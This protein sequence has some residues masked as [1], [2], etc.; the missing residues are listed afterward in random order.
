MN[1]LASLTNPTQLLEG[2]SLD[3]PEAP[4]TSAPLTA[5]LAALN[6]TDTSQPSIVE[7]L[8]SLTEEYTGLIES[9][10]ELEVR[11]KAASQE[12]Q[13]NVEAL[14]NVYNEA[15]KAN[16]SQPVLDSIVGAAQNLI[17]QDIALTE[18]YALEKRAIQSVQDMAS[19][20]PVQAELLF[21]NLYYGGPDDIVRDINTKYMIVDR[22]IRRA[23]IDVD[24]QPWFNDVTNFL[25]SW[26]PLNYS[27]SRADLVDMDKA[28]KNWYDGILPGE[29]LER[30]S[31][32]MFDVPLE[33][34]TG[35]V[36]DE[37]IPRV[38][39][40]STLFGYFDQ[41]E[42]LNLMSEV[43]RV[44]NANMTNFW[45]TVD[46]IGLIPT[47][48]I[49]K[50]I[51]IPSTLVRLGA[52]K[53]AAETI[54][55]AAFEMATDGAEA[56]LRKTG[57]KEAEVVEGLAVSAVKVDPP[58]TTVPLAVDAISDIERATSLIDK[59]PDVLTTSRFA[60]DNEFRAAV[61][62]TIKK[63]GEEVGRELK[64][65]KVNGK[66]ADTVSM[67][68]GARLA[69][70]SR[71]YGI[72]MT[73][74][75]KSGGG[76]SR[77]AQAR[78]YAKSL[79]YPDAEIIRDESGQFFVKI[80]RDMPETGF[81]TNLL[82]P[83]TT[84]VFGR[85]L[86]GSRRISDAYLA[87]L[88]QAA[89]NKRSR[90][91]VELLQPY[92]D[93][94]RVLNKNEKESLTQVLAAGNNQNTWFTRDQLEILYQRGYKRSPTE[95][96]I[97]AYNAYREINDIEWVLRRDDAYKSRLVKGYETV[98][99]N[100]PIIEVTETNALID[101]KM[102]KVPSDNRVYNL[103]D[104]VHYHRNNPVPVKDLQEK[105]YYLVNL[106]RGTKLADGTEIRTFVVKPSD[107][108]IKPLSRDQ[109]PYRAGGH[110]MYADK[111]F[112][113][114]ASQGVQPDTG[115]KFYRN[116]STFITGTRREVE[117]WVG[118]META[119]LAVKAAE[120]AGEQISARA[121]DD[122]FGGAKGYPTG[123]EFLK[124]IEDGTFDKD[125]PF[126][127]LYDRELPPSTGG[128][129]IGDVDESGF[130]QWM[131]TTGRMFYS[132]RGEHLKDWQGDLA[133]TLDPF[134][135]LNK[136][137]MN[138]ANITSFSDY[139]VT[140]IERWVKTFGQYT[141]LKNFKGNTT[142]LIAFS[143]AVFDRT[144]PE[145]IKQ[146]GLA[147]RDVIRRLLS[148]KSDSDLA[149]EQM[150][151]RAAEF[152]FRGAPGSKLAA[153][154][155]IVTNWWDTNNPVQALRSAAFDMKLGLFNLAQLPLQM[156][157]MAATLS[158]SPK[159]G[160]ASMVNLMPYRVYLTK[161]GTDH[162][163]NELVNRGLHTAS[164]FKTSAE[165][166]EFMKAGKKSGFF[167]FNVNHQ[168][169]N[170][171]G[172]NAAISQFG[173]NVTSVR[174]AGR[175]FFNEPE[176]WNRILAWHVGWK[177]TADAFPKLKTNSPEFLQR[178]Q[179]RAEEYALSMSEQSAAWWQRGLMSVPT[180]FFSY[181][182]RMIEA[183][184][185]KTFT[186]QQK[187]RLVT[188]QTLLYGSAGV[189]FLPFITERIKGAQGDAPD[190]NTFFGTLDRGTLDRL[191]YEVTGVD[192]K[193][194]ERFGTGGWL[195]QQVED[196]FGL[197]EYGERNLAEMAGGATFSIFGQVGKTIYDVAR[198]GVAESGGDSGMPVTEGAL[199]RLAA[200]ISSV[201]NLMKS[202]Y[203]AQ[204]GIWRTNT[205]NAIIHGLP[206]SNAVA[207]L[208]GF[209]PGQMD[210]VSARM[211][212]SKHRSKTVQDAAKVLQQ[213]R[214]R[215]INE[216]DNYED[217]LEE[218]NAFSKMLPPDI[219]MEAIARAN[220]QMDRS[221]YEGLER[222]VRE[223]QMQS[224]LING[225]TN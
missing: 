127:T 224:E 5:R 86:K 44:P 29:S 97:K 217:I 175:W 189:P 20:D 181:Q 56:A 59:L 157:T 40:K 57:V 222:R 154:E 73:V 136:S 9:V 34:F 31:A 54:A 75:K 27:F 12:Q 166:K 16:Q 67:T 76:W 176:L 89:G 140:A 186:P 8:N 205:G 23:G 61:E 4:V 37:L 153:A 223:K 81:Y 72:E 22:E 165:Y 78:N 101:R 131:N 147:Q 46:N 148:W 105:G 130:D 164:G 70:Q 47:A 95:R 106:E 6:D 55:Q 84:S 18:Q 10:G 96:E 77:E 200:N 204:Y 152:V 79:G 141:N 167:D 142:D 177:E 88:G 202:A 65:V 118:K 30:A 51:S 38:R 74:G 107:L 123:E 172:P 24:T 126:M 21:N 80:Q 178:V 156:S 1:E 190:I 160:F 174:N 145:H 68:D 122:I 207:A 102:S 39:E 129:F 85:F 14:A 71:V 187:L 219:R 99:F 52:R 198:Y 42:Y 133:P 112:A 169:V 48:A 98:S 2:L 179:G 194:G 100:N 196:I 113:K 33:N 132:R 150:T 50:G 182:A 3:T 124:N 15:R 159:Y 183:M 195:A 111:Y 192:A 60:D 197:G 225:A 35:F 185:G 215:L 90:I 146:A 173:A 7:Q 203:V 116:P 162:M 109:L 28:M 94:F 104:G 135:A 214:T 120:E 137:L 125:N 58:S 163:L 216:P 138:I 144:T 128:E 115:E 41:N 184:F 32:T 62:K 63:L 45:A 188:V 64:D 134:E 19:R 193:F 119:R 69:D 149:V 91:V 143:E 206:D 209:A 82:T 139:K 36:R 93:T 87:N 11:R 151:R 92:E 17:A 25:L 43:R 117:E 191:M 201:S 212:W 66:P 208:F 171:Y 218:M 49:T 110:R 199:K 53:E 220:G 168:L 103:S 155:R 211:A 161:S 213:Y 121:I 26:L 108:N 13:E 170:S 114:Q 83:R 180:Q 210:E 221:L 158:L